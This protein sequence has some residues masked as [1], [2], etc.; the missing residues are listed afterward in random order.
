MD[1]VILCGGK[2]TRL[3]SVVQDVPKPLAPVHQRPF[4]DYLLDFLHASGLVQRVLLATGHLAHKVREHYGTH[5]RG[6][7]LCYSVE[8]Q[9][10][11]TAGAVRLLQSRYPMTQPF[12]LLNGDSFVDVDLHALLVLH[13]AQSVALTMSLFAVADAAR[14]GTVTLDGSRVRAFH[15]KGGISEAGLIN[16]G[17][18]LLQ[19]DALQQWAASDGMLSLET[20]VLPVL[21]ARQQVAGLQSGA[22][23]IDIGL[24][25]TYRA[26]LDFFPL[27]AA[28]VYG[29][30]G[31]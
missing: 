17:V 13:Q 20:E 3:A 28:E 26:A 7:P 29:N 27:T 12:L 14:F 2:G 30:A 24:P 16:A 10:L 8:P 5:Y 25:E 6:L 19:P 22:R 23:F 18:Y 11:G 4:L 15:E 21:V 9:P 31:V 1:A